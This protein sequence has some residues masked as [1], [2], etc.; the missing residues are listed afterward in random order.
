MGQLTKDDITVWC[1]SLT[2]GL[3]DLASAL[4]V[5]NAAI[6]H[7][8]PPEKAVALTVIYDVI[9]FAAQPFAGIVIDYVKCA[10]SAMLL[11]IA[12]TLAGVIFMRANAIS[13][14]V[15]VGVGN[16]L[17]HLGAGAQILSRYPNTAATI[18]IF[19]GPGALGLSIGFWFGSRGFFP[20]WSLVVALFV[21]CIGLALLPA[22]K[23]KPDLIRNASFQKRSRPGVLL[24]LFAAIALR[25]FVGRTGFA[26]LPSEAFATIGL[27]AAAC[28]GK[29]AGG[30]VADRL[31]WGRSVIIALVLASI[32]IVFVRNHLGV[33]FATMLFFQ[34]T[35]PI[36]LAATSAAIPG[37]PAFAFGLT[38]L[39][40]VSG[41]FPAFCIPQEPLPLPF[42]LAMIGGSG[43]CI[44]AALWRMGTH[45]LRR[46]RSYRYR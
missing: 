25:G 36:T 32:G 7:G 11:G 8:L 28:V 18:G 20:F 33:A 38:C 44:I 16:A 12:L 26:G 24:L 14:I 13:G 10:R 34:M 5:Y 30:A 22:L 3:V 4:V 40:L 27:G 46:N 19:V 35:M 43:G 17:F 2:H 21:A 23:A 1:F 15:V 29:M 31:G 42:T 9:A 6:V 37:K 39:A 41:T 45:D